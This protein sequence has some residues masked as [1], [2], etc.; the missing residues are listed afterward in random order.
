MPRH[1]IRLV[2]LMIV[3]G[4]VGYA[5]KT[6]F[7]VNSFYEFGHYRG[8]SVAEI[9]SDKPR[10]KGLTY[11]ESCHAEQF[12]EWSKGVHNKVDIGKVVKCEVCHGAAGDR[13]VRG[14]FDHVATGRD[15]PDK[16]KLVVPT[17]Y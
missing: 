10:Y 8:K 4:A 5:A 3:F 11:C 7:T 1:I 6:L 13:D 15:H 12:A 17:D 16:L 9:A 2:F 14:M